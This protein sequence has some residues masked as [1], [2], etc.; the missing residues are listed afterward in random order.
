MKTHL[1]WELSRLMTET[2]TNQTE[3]ASKLEMTQAALSALITKDI[4]PKEATL[5]GLVHCWPL[6]GQKMRVLLAHLHDEARRAGMDVSK[7]TVDGVNAVGGQDDEFTVIRRVYENDT[8]VKQIVDRFA[9]LC[10]RIEGKNCA[11]RDELK[12]VA[13]KRVKF[14][15]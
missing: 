10:K 4:R 6:G 7:I 15:E 11:G 1:G 13:E 8:L 9:T 12:L 14:M 5:F 3:L 2:D